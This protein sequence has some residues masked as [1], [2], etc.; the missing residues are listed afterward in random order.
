MRVGRYVIWGLADTVIL[1][2]NRHVRYLGINTPEIDYKR[3]RADPFAYAARRLNRKMVDGQKV[4]LEFE[5]KRTDRFG[6]LLAY[7]FLENKTFVN[8]AL[9]ASGYG[10]YYPSSHPG[11]YDEILF[12]AQREAMSARKGIWRQWREPDQRGGYIANRR[13]KR[14]HS[15]DC[16]NGKKVSR[17]NRVSYR[18][19][20]DAHW[21]GYAPAKQCILNHK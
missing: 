20:W 15:A 6:R 10:Y 3:H 17:K 11:K 21:A 9:L 19:M 5:K 7:I 16:P 14:F 18:T 1:K 2:D 13:S 4:R 12:K 8:R